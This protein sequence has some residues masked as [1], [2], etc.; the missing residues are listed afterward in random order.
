MNHILNYTRI[1]HIYYLFTL[2]KDIIFIEQEFAAFSFFGPNKTRV[3]G[4]PCD[5]WRTG[6]WE[7][8]QFESPLL[9]T[10]EGNYDICDTYQSFRFN[11]WIKLIY[12][13]KQKII[14][15]IFVVL[16][17]CNDYIRGRIAKIFQINTGNTPE[18]IYALWLTVCKPETRIFK[19]FR[20]KEFEIHIYN[21]SVGRQLPIDFYQINVTKI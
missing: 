20:N 15:Y 6:K 11:L 2:Y 19:F 7:Y 18:R 1:L 8:F 13:L 16:K 17:V 3:I 12:S 10:F 21:Q 14:I 4:K 5:R 9:N